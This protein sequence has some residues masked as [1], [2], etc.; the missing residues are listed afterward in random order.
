MNVVELSQT[1]LKGACPNFHR[2]CVMCSSGKEH[3]S[4]EIHNAAQSSLIPRPHTRK[5]G[6]A[7]PFPWHFPISVCLFF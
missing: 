4:R 6:V 2:S 1:S 3:T 5:E 7:S